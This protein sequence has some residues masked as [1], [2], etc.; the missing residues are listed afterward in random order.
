MVTGENGVFDFRDD[1]LVEADDAGKDLF[2]PGDHFEQ[3]A[4]HLLAHR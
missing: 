2:A 4:P 3:V 1:A